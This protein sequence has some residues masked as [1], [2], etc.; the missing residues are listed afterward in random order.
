MASL[1]LLNSAASSSLGAIVSETSESFSIERDRSTAG[2]VEQDSGDEKGDAE[3]ELSSS[4]I[5]SGISITAAGVAF[6]R[7]G[8][9]GESGFFGGDFVASDAFLGRGLDVFFSL[10]G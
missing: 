6:L 2:G 8:V 4:D 9:A 7:F 5:E 3:T 1:I 10:A